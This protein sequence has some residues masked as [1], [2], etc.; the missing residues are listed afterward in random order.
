MTSVISS[1]AF[2][3]E[4]ADI[5]AALPCYQ[6]LAGEQDVN[7]YDFPEF[8]LASVGPF[9]LLQGDP[10]TLA[11]FRRDGTLTVTDLEA[12]VAAFVNNGGSVVDGPTAAA[13]G[14]RT[15]VQ[16]RDGNVFECFRPGA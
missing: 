2:R 15:I 7:R 3:I 9:L 4:V 10:E 8:A 13:G 12:A 16:D 6:E 1:V 14:T 11:K 5:T